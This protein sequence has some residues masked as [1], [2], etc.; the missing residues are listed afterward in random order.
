M[1]FGN[2][3]PRQYFKIKEGNIVIS[4]N[5]TDEA[6]FQTLIKSAKGTSKYINKN[7]VQKI[8]IQYDDFTGNLKKIESYD[9]EFNGKKVKQWKLHFEENGKVYIGTL[10]YS[11]FV[12]QDFMNRISS[13]EGPIGKITIKPYIFGDGKTG[14]SVRH[15]GVKLSCKFSKDEKPPLET[16]KTF[17]DDGV[18]VVDDIDEVTG[19]TR[20][21]DKKR[22]AWLLEMI[23]NINDRIGADKYVTSSVDNNDDIDDEHDNDSEQPF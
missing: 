20:I 17:A 19:K 16:K 23:V 3:K 22:M 6:N 1:G 2:N 14:V 9:A 7:G 10:D 15:K 13:I 4:I 21:N 11:S 18:T 8:D 12:M 5:A